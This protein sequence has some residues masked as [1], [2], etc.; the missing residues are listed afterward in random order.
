MNDYLGACRVVGQM[1][2]FAGISGYTQVCLTP[3][4]TLECP[5]IERILETG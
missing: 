5:N 2:A 4:N 1:S 3:A